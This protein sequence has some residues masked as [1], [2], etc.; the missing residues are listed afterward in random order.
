MRHFFKDNFTDSQMQVSLYSFE[1]QWL[2]Y[3]SPGFVLGV[4]LRTN[5]DY[6]TVHY[7]SSAIEA[8]FDFFVLIASSVVAIHTDTGTSLSLI[9]ALNY[10]LICTLMCT[11]IFTLMCTLICALICKLISTLIFTLICTLI[12]TL[13]C[14]LIFTLICTLIFTLICAILYTDMY[15][16]LYTNLYANV[17]VISR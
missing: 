4:D 16:I 14:T 13:I 2:L 15:S 7:L 3:I 6:F 1:A 17:F 11:L 10:T 5:S 9:C 8:L 12:F